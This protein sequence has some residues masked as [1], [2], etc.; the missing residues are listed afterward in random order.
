MNQEKQT[1][2]PQPMYTPRTYR[3]D[4]RGDGLV[5]VDAGSRDGE[6]Q[7]QVVPGRR[8]RD[9]GCVMEFSSRRGRW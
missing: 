5:A 6:V 7:D 1:R 8:V 3:D 4:D 2:T 9:R